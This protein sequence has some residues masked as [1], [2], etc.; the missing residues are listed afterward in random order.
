MSWT[1]SLVAAIVAAVAGGTTPP[2]EAV[3]PVLT[4]LPPSA[5]VPTAVPT[6]LPSDDTAAR[7]L[8]TT[9]LRDGPGGAVVARLRATTEFGSPRIV[10]VVRREGR[11]LGVI[12]TERPNGALGWV[13]ASAVR[14]IGEPERIDVDLSARALRVVDDGHTVFRMKVDIGSAS[15]PTPTGSFAVTDSLHGWGPYGCCIL[16]LSGHQTKLAQG[17]TGGDRLAVHGASTATGRGDAASLGCL[18]GDDADMR[19]L[20]RIA[21]LGTRVRIRA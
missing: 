1:H 9:A 15:T 4:P 17:W 20:L 6:P 5:N 18:R 12:A 7:V 13:R 10:P 2:Q 19:R 3:R 14:L 11:W 16:A 21:R 8:A